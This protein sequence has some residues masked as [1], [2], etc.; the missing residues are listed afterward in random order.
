MFHC[1]YNAAVSGPSGNVTVNGSLTYGAGVQTLDSSSRDN[2]AL[3]MRSTASTSGP[4]YAIHNGERLSA[5]PLSTI[6]HQFFS[7]AL[8]DLSLQ[9]IAVNATHYGGRTELE[10][11]NL[12]GHLMSRAAN[13]AVRELHQGKR[14]FLI[15]RSTFAGSGRWTGHWVCGIFL[16]GWEDP[17]LICCSTLSWEITGASGRTCTTAS[18]AYCS[19]NSSKFRW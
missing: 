14:P 5:C 9:T 2:D 18:R 8:G 12:F 16:V 17:S 13:L 1:R 7:A 4:L 15:S 11:H 19:S 6:S 3:S 10:M